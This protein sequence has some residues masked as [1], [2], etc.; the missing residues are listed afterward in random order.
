MLSMQINDTLWSLNGNIWYLN[1]NGQEVSLSSKQDWRNMIK[2]Q[3]SLKIQM[4]KKLSSEEI[5]GNNHV[6]DCV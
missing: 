3:I 6:K 1:M 2:I 5:S 4:V